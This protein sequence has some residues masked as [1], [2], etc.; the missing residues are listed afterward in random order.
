MPPP[1]PPSKRR[2]VKKFAAHGHHGGAWK[3]AYADFVTAM[4]ALFM[5]LWLLASTDQKSRDEIARYFRS[6]IL[7]DAEMAMNG[8]AQYV[9]AIMEKAP[10]PTPPDAAT[11]ADLKTLKQEIRDVAA[12]HAE[13]ADIAAQVRVVATAE[14]TLIE[15]VDE[16]G[17]GGLLFDSASARLKPA[18]V[19]FLQVLAPVLADRPETLEILGHTDAT[20]FPAGASRSNWELSFERAASARKIFERGGVNPDRIVGVI[21][22]GAATP[23]EPEHPYAA[24]NRRLSVL[25]RKVAPTAG[26]D[27]IDAPATPDAADAPATAAP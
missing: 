4:M 20:R 13:L 12:N 15:I 8:G 25:L 18:L 23:L 27:V 7:P 10:T 26:I 5:V 22:R 17:G 1:P 21:G 19:T 16:D 24:K 3:I 14:G 6:G 9:P 2:I 11:M